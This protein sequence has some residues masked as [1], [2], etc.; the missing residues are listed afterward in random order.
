M[1]SV[2]FFVAENVYVTP[3]ALMLLTYYPYAFFPWFQICIQQVVWR[4]YFHWNLIWKTLIIEE[5][6]Q[7]SAQGVSNRSKRNHRKPAWMNDYISCIKVTRR[8]SQRLIHQSQLNS[9]I[10]SILT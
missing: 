6:E 7:S 10:S 8:I 9:S 1:L 5:K 4:S 3:L 2:L